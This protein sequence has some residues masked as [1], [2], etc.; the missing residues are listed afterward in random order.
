MCEQNM[1]SGRKERVYLEQKDEIRR[2]LPSFAALFALHPFH[3]HKVFVF[4]TSLTRST[5]L[6]LA[7]EA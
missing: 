1:V 3:G 7:V 6:A 4:S 5:A 2:G